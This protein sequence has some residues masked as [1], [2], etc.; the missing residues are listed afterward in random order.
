MEGKP[1]MMTVNIH[2]RV[3]GI[4][5]REVGLR[6]NDTL[7]GEFDV[8]VQDPRLGPFAIHEEFVLEIVDSTGESPDWREVSFLELK[9]FCARLTVTSEAAKLCQAISL[10]N[11]VTDFEKESSP[12]VAPE[13]F[14]RIPVEGDNNHLSRAEEAFERRGVRFRLVG[15]Q[16][17]AGRH[18]G[19]ASYVVSDLLEA[20]KCLHGA[21]FFLRTNSKYLFTDK[22][23]G[24]NIRLLPMATN[25]CS[26]C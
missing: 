16:G 17:S 19:H 5:Y 18:W 24:W 11:V 6:P 26:A 23:N 14:P 22:V 15:G 21:G 7:R 20:G 12:Q 10:R 25:R 3:N 8:L 4:E 13:P 9:R 1:G 2:L